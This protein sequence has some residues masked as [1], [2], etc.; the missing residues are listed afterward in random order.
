M[1]GKGGL[2]Y[3]GEQGMCRGW[4][5]QRTVDKVRHTT[6]YITCRLRCPPFRD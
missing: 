5:D 1:V 4:P 2:E 6:L 3:A